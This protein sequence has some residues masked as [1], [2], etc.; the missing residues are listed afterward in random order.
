MTSITVTATAEAK[1]VQLFLKSLHTD[2]TR[3]VYQRAYRIIL[4]NRPDEFLALARTNKKEAE[5]KVLTWIFDH[6]DKLSG[7]TIRTW[8]AAIRSLTD[9]NEVVLNW[10]KIIKVSPHISKAHDRAPTLKEVQQLYNVSNT[11]MKF[12]ITLLAS[13]GIRAGSFEYFTVRDLKLL[14]EGIGLLTVYRDENE[15]Y[16][17]FVSTECIEHFK[18]Y[19]SERERAGEK[20]IDNS[21]LVRQEVNLAEYTEPRKLTVY[22]LEKMLYYQWHRIGIVDRDFKQVHG[23]RKYF[24]THLEASGMKTIN[25]EM[26]M[27]HASGLS[28]NYYRPSVEEM[29]KEY[30]QYQSALLINEAT[31]AK[32]DIAKLREEYQSRNMVSREEYEELK[33]LVKQNMARSEFVFLNILTPE[34]K[35]LALKEVR[36]RFPVP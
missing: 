23:F 4:D 8:L 5:A 24:K 27:G 15:E 2:K 1:E 6:Q 29:K 11:R 16:Q 25:V 14:D 10:D 21:P 9:F 36:S 32:K 17:T 26:L 3:E 20:I 13:S 33:D 34:Q 19:K 12:V 18:A 35:V 30:V 31:E 7:S 28:E 22:A